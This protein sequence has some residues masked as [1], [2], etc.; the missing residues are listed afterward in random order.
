MMV[1]KKIHISSI[2]SSLA[3]LFAGLAL[4]AC[5]DI[6][7]TPDESQKVQNVS[8][9]VKQEGVIDSTLLK[10]IHKILRKF[11][12]LSTPTNIPKI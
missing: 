3:A 7:S 2:L 9:Y 10:F 6:P 4:S 11:T 1:F 8:I 12:R 5:F